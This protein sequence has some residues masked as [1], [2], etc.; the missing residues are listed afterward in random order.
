MPLEM[1]AVIYAEND[2]QIAEV[3][4]NIRRLVKRGCIYDNQ[5]EEEVAYSFSISGYPPKEL[6]PVWTIGQD[7]D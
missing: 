3:L 5:K 4:G 2:E 7:R 1:T 6:D